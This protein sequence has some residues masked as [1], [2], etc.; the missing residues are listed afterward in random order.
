MKICTG[1]TTATVGVDYKIKTICV[2][3]KNVKL[4]AWDSAGQERFR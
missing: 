4:Q 2:N 1:E 3:D